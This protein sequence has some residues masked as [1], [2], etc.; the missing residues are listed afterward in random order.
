MEEFPYI[1]INENELIWQ[2]DCFGYHITEKKNI[3]SII[4]KG[5]IPMCGERSQYV[6]EK[7]EAI[8]FTQSLF[9]VNNWIAKLYPNE[10]MRNLILLRM[11]LINRKIKIRDVWHEDYHFYD[12]VMPNEI[13]FLLIKRKQEIVTLDALPSVL[14]QYPGYSVEWCKLTKY[15]HLK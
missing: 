1:F 5:L 10:D 14:F 15:K 6:K 3:L 12:S 4:E 8:W 9:Q 2:E 13:D 11:N 7:E